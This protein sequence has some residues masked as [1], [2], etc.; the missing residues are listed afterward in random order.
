MNSCSGF[1][2]GMAGPSRIALP[3]LVLPAWERAYEAALAE[4][5]L[6]L[7]A[8]ICPV[9]TTDER[10]RRGGWTA[11]YPR[12]HYELAPGT[13]VAVAPGSGRVPHRA[14]VAH[15]DG[16]AEVTFAEAED[17]IDPAGAGRRAWRRRIARAWLTE[18][19]RRHRMTPGHGYVVDEVY[20]WGGEEYAAVCTK[21]GPSYVWLRAVTY[22]EAQALGIA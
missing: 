18:T 8:R 22:A 9:D 19:P 13:V 20:D 3:V 6:A 15:A 11:G 17:L 12:A 21:A 10:V 5:C 16:V 2:D 4:D 1:K 14:H 7:G